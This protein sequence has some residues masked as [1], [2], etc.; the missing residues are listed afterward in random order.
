[1]P[2]EESDCTMDVEA[3]VTET[4]KM[5][6]ESDWCMDIEADVTGEL[7]SKEES[8][9]CMDIEVDITGELM[10][11]EQDHFMNVDADDMEIML[12]EEAVQDVVDPEVFDEANQMQVDKLY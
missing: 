11:E 8:D 9:W 1:M 12:I 6:E 4:L 2:E 3:H 5:I 7:T 10:P